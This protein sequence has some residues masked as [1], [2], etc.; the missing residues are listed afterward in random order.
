MSVQHF[1]KSLLTLPLQTLLNVL[2][3]AG[4]EP[5]LALGRTYFQIRELQCR[6]QRGRL[7]LL[8]VVSQLQPSQLF[9]AYA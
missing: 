4:H 9:G 1:G 2:Q 3:F 7:D 6:S 8:G 5:D